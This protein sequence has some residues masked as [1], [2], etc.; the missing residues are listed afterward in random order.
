MYGFVCDSLQV[1][2]QSSRLNIKFLEFIFNYCCAHLYSNHGL[3]KM[4]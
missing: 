2:R 1:A 4:F 3:K